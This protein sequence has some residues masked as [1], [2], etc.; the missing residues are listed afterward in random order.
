MAPALLH[1]LESSKIVG[2]LGSAGT[3]GVNVL[4]QIS[5]ANTAPAPLGGTNHHAWIPILSATVPLAQPSLLPPT[6]PT[7]LI[8]AAAAPREEEQTNTTTEE[9][10]EMSEEADTKQ[11]EPLA[12]ANESAAPLATASNGSDDAIGIAAPRVQHSTDVA[13]VQDQRETISATQETWPHVENQKTL[14]MSAVQ[15]GHEETRSSAADPDAHMID[16]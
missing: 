10:N 5:A 6:V 4:N 12:N 16:Q 8:E 13:L 11:T 2:E 15:D 9:V 3:T 7:G 14:S 1:G